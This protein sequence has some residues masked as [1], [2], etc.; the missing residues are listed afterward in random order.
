[1]S[2]AAPA[3]R[4]SLTVKGSANY[5]K[6]SPVL[7][8][9]AGLLFVLGCSSYLVGATLNV[10]TVNVADAWMYSAHGAGVFILCG[11]IEYCN[12][13]GNFHFFLVLAG[14]LALAAE[15][16]DSTQDPVSVHLN[17]VARHMYF[18][19]AIK[20]YYAHYGDFYFLEI[21][22]KYI[23]VET[24]KIADVCFILGTLIDLVLS[25]IYLFVGGNDLGDGAS[26]LSEA[27][28][29]EHKYIEVGSAS[30]WFIC[31]ILTLI[32]YIQ[33]ARAK[34]N[35]GD[36]DEKVRLSSDV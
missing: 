2:Y 31:S 6:E 24:L 32:V 26:Y 25:W 29:D 9:I 33:M 27:K 14:G 19:E 12:Y 11:L 5:D 36:D 1:M 16:K 20:N 22:S 3:K 30:L 8:I 18:C 34:A 17:F 28:T 7:T 21:A 4:P 35:V 10:P 23:M 15:I 13:M